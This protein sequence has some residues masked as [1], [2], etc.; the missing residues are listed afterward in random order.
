[1]IF[2]GHKI[3]YNEELYHHGV[4]GM[5][6]GVRRQRKRQAIINS[7]ATLAAKRADMYR[8]DAKRYSNDKNRQAASKK[9]MKRWEKASQNAA[10]YF[11]SKKEE[12]SKLSA[13][14]IS[15]KQV[16]AAEKW[17]KSYRSHH[18]AEYTDVLS[19]RGTTNYLNNLA[20][21]DERRRR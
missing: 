15:R 12:F 21:M 4:R 8:E 19:R 9:D 2:V 14:K 5:K 16:K 7:A 1:M 3:L 10:K 18:D 20:E 6:W 13:S 11:D 17:M